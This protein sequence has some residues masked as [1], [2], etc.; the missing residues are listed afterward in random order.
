MFKAVLVFV[1][2]AALAG[3]PLLP[4]LAMPLTPDT[5]LAPNAPAATLTVNT[6]DDELNTDGD[7]SLREAITSANTDTAVDACAAG[8][9]LDLITFSVDGLITLGSTL[10][11][12]NDDVTIDGTNHTI[13]VNGAGSFSVMVV[14]S[15]VI[16]D[17][18]SLTITNG[19]ASAGAGINNAGT[20]TVANRT[21]I[22][23]RATTNGGGLYNDVGGTATVINSTFSGNSATSSGAS[24]GGFFNLGTLTVTNSVFNNNS[25]VA[26]SAGGA[27]RY[28]DSDGQH[29]H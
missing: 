24:G 10:P 29:Q 2:V 4:V 19:S 6:I 17:L 26:H 11:L 9:G 22:S 12:I 5:L 20:L 25:A 23:N 1:T 28:T 13:T 16:V 15:G 8:S 27:R 18:I 21:F 14:A 3:Q 7:C